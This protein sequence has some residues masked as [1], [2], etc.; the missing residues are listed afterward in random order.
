MR[1][2][3]WVVVWSVVVAA[4]FLAIGLLGYLYQAIVP[5]KINDMVDLS[6]SLQDPRTVAELAYTLFDQYPLR[7]LS[8]DSLADAPTSD[9]DSLPVS[10]GTQRIF[11]QL[12]P[13]MQYAISL[14]DATFALECFAD[15]ELI[16][17]FGT[18]ADTAEET[19]ALAGTLWCSFIPTGDSTELVI[20]YASFVRSNT[21]TSLF[22]GQESAVLGRLQAYQLRNALQIGCIL[23]ASLF[24]LGLFCFFDQRRVFF[25]LRPVLHGHCDVYACCRRNAAFL[26]VSHHQPRGGAHR[27]QHGRA[28]RDGLHRLHESG[29]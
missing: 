3:L 25:V 21:L 20:R 29:V 26:M 24:F 19:R 7:L 6:E 18:V 5:E 15:G 16:G 17:S 13:G 28:C 12:E 10:Y 11:L 14:S 8:P 9:L 27:V 22:I 2:R 1:R 23:T 4:C